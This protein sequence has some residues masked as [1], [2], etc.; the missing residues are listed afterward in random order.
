M[1]QN[2][3]GTLVVARR[4]GEQEEGSKRPMYLPCEFCLGFYRED[5]LWKHVTNHCWHKP[6]TTVSSN[7]VRNSKLL[8]APYVRRNS[9][10]TPLD[11]FFNR[12][13]ET[14]E[15]PGVPDLCKNDELI[16]EFAQSLLERIGDESDQRR[17]DADNMRTKVRTVG[18]LLK[19]LQEL[20]GQTKAMSFF[21]TGTYFQAVVDAVK[22]MS[23][24]SNSP[25]LAI[26]L[27]HYIKQL[28]LLK[29][30][31]S[32]A[33]E[34]EIS[35]KE[36]KAFGAA[37]EAHWNNKVSHVANRRATMRTLNKP[38]NLPPTA[39]LMM[40]KNFLMKSI[41]KAEKNLT[42]THEEWKKTAEKVL[43]RLALY[44]RRRIGEV[45]EL[46]LDD[47]ARKASQEN[48]EVLAA[49]DP[50]EKALASRYILHIYPSDAIQFYL[51]M[52]HSIFFL[53]FHFFIEWN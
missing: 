42:P 15:N 35:R 29:R 46:T 7:A 4:P 16:R 37:Y 20:T 28:N 39:D 43:V 22:D 41:V 31:T 12:M 32:Y 11:D 44:N 24:Q 47:Y 9:D 36:S 17:K 26:V 49:L 38:D 53:F 23:I 50:S 27:G 51:I 30:T 48:P 3:D 2:G 18:R 34:D 45:E 25:S 1:I 33:K 8:I 40:L 21:L 5:V 19:K 14:K 13:K 6:E 10:E 52:F